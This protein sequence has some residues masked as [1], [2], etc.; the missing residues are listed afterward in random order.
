MPCYRMDTVLNGLLKH[1]PIKR[2][3]ALSDRVGLLPERMARSRKNPMTF[4]ARLA[5]FSV[6]ITGYTAWAA[7][8]YVFQ[9]DWERTI[10][11]HDWAASGYQ[12]SMILIACLLA[13]WVLLKGRI[14]EFVT[15][16]IAHAFSSFS[17]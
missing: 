14:T 5:I 10:L 2:F 3:E 7:Y 17:I 11:L 15:N 6:A 16:A 13:D 4:K 12:F 8:D 9:Q 1:V